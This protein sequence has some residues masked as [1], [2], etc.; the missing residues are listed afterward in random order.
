V[1]LFADGCV[2][3]LPPELAA[4]APLLSRGRCIDSASL[5]PLLRRRAFRALL[6]DLVG[7][8]VF[9]VQRRLSTAGAA[10]GRR[11]NPRAQ[12]S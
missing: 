3:E 8:G 9:R 10:R 2:W 11:G 5:V 6:T 7:A 12:W 1:R 4:A